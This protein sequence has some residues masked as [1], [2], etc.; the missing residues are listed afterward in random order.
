NVQVEVVEVPTECADVEASSV[1]VVSST[2]SNSSA[3]P[4]MLLKNNGHNGI[5]LIF[6]LPSPAECVTLKYHFKGGDRIFCLSVNGDLVSGPSPSDLGGQEV[7][8]A[9]ITTT[10]TSEN[11]PSLGDQTG[12]IKINAC[13]A[14]QIQTLGIYGVY[15]RLYIDDLCSCECETQCP[16]ECDPDESRIELLF[17]GDDNFDPDED[18]PPASP[19]GNLL[20]A[21]EDNQYEE[22]GFD[23]PVINSEF[24]HTFTWEPSTCG[25]ITKA[26]LVLKIQAIDGQPETDWINLWFTG[27]YTDP[28]YGGINYRIWSEQTEASQTAVICLDLGSLPEEGTNL[29]TGPTSGNQSLLNQLNTSG[30]LD[31]RVQ[32]DTSVDYANLILCCGAE[33]CQCGEWGDVQVTWTDASG[34]AQSWTGSCGQSV[35]PEV[36]VIPLGNSIKLNSTI[37]CSEGCTPEYT[38]E[39]TFYSGMTLPSPSFG[40]GLPAEFTPQE[41]GLNSYDVVL[42]AE[43]DGVGCPTCTINMRV[44]VEEAEECQCTEWNDV[45]VSWPGH[46]ATAN[47]GD[48]I[49]VVIDNPGDEII[50]TSGV[51]CTPFNADTCAPEYGEWEV[52]KLPDSIIASGTGPPVS[53]DP[54]GDGT[55]EVVAN[56]ECDGN[57]CPPC[58]ITLKVDDAEEPTP[59]QCGGWKAAFHGE[60]GNVKVTL[61][62]HWLT[63]PGEPGEGIVDV[64]LHDCGDTV[65]LG[66]PQGPGYTASVTLNSVMTC[67]P[68]DCEATHTYTVVKPDG[69]YLYE[70]EPGHTVQLD[71][72]PPYGEYKVILNSSCN[73]TT[74]PPCE[75][76][77]DFK[78]PECPADCKCLTPAQAETGQWLP[79]NNQEIECCPPQNG[80]CYESCEIKKKTFT[81]CRCDNFSG[82]SEPTNPRS[83][84]IDW[85]A[86]N[87]AFPDIKS[88][89]DPTE[90]RYWAHSFTDLAIPGYLCEIQSATLEIRVRNGGS[91]DH[92]KIG[93]ISTPNDSWAVNSRLT[94]FGV[95]VGQSGTITLDLSD[96]MDQNLLYDM[97]VHG[98]LDVAVDDDS[99]VDCAKLGLTYCCTQVKTRRG[100]KGGFAIGG[101]SPA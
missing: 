20:S 60:Q 33:E 45:Q 15:Q 68:E 98:F 69:T 13:G 85:V 22:V 39:V 41:S 5:G 3:E 30:H 19:S 11:Q 82:E 91:N 21:V 26:W 77:V 52:R 40:S 42:N 95:P 83:E 9:T 25:N 76:F 24:V 64:M 89:D 2:N 90:N 75:I 81:V 54:P 73:N 18:T 58:T 55:Y 87:Y 47:C 84:L 35:Y 65:T 49:S 31:L 34:N 96:V 37:G 36:P 43:C 67:E 46:S 28:P 7:G 10:I 44:K 48:T 38:W 32:D 27:D 4:E 29:I 63:E 72:G 16:D 93:F 56:A 101:F 62:S 100:F 74:C 23:H 94:D 80:Y 14:A 51:T 92:L 99:N 6:E 59:C 50:L 17:G 1:S 66:P 53:F 86:A 97:M 71:Y 8:G 79:C 88:C 70:N 78:C 61:E 12:I 57:P